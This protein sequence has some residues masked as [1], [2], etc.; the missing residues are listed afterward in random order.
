M[1]FL[2]GFMKQECSSAVAYEQ[3]LRIRIEA[4]T[5][6]LRHTVIQ[7]YSS[8]GKKRARACLRKQGRQFENE[9]KLFTSYLL[10]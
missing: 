1:H 7:S 10:I 3:E 8:S 5:E 6:S 9:L 2:G 4:V